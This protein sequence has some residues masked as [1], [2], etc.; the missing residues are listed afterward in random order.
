MDFSSTTPQK[1][2]F[3]KV[4]FC[5]DC[6]FDIL[7][8]ENIMQLE[9]KTHTNLLSP[10]TPFCGVWYWYNATRPCLCMASNFVAFAQTSH[11]F[12]VVSPTGKSAFA[13][14]GQKESWW[15]T[16]GGKK[17]KKMP[18][19]RSMGSNGFLL[20][21][22]FCEV[23]VGFPRVSNERIEQLARVERSNRFCSFKNFLS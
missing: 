23:F 15:V 8:W 5:A 20:V 12:S 22:V 7:S 18:R 11:H 17:M 6:L 4:H 9:Q 14:F 1:W 10:E 16:K 2:L 3:K 13:I 21:I 19:N